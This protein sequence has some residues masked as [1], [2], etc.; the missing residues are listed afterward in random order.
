MIAKILLFL[1]PI[2][3]F[4][5][6]EILVYFSIV[7]GQGGHML[8]FTA[9]FFVQFMMCMYIMHTLVNISKGSD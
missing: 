5:G 7:E 6:F 8:S 9:I 1:L 4:A 3:T 2:S